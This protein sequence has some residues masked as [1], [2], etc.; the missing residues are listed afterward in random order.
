[1]GAFHA[2]VPARIQV[3]ELTESVQVAEEDRFDIRSITARSCVRPLNEARARR[4]ARLIKGKDKGGGGLGVMKARKRASA[5]GPLHLLANA[6]APRLRG[7][8]HA[9]RV[10][11][12]RRVQMLGRI[13]VVEDHLDENGNAVV[14]LCDGAHRQYPLGAAAQPP[15]GA[16][17][18]IQT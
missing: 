4:I 15:N 6:P 12:W 17:C 10:P 11:P 3:E 14:L 9:W 1:M 18:A 2:V 8:E 13:L 5:S 7:P 16:K